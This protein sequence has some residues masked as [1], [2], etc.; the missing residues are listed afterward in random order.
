MQPF[1]YADRSQLEDFDELCIQYGRHVNVLTQDCPAL[2]LLYDRLRETGIEGQEFTRRLALAFEIK[3]GFAHTHYDLTTVAGLENQHIVPRDRRESYRPLANVGSFTVALSRSRAAFAM[4]TR[5]RS[6]WDKAFLYVA[7]T[8]DGDAA[9]RQLQAARSKRR[10]FFSRFGDGFGAVS[11]QMIVE[12]KDDLTTLE[13]QFRT[14]ELHGFGN[15]RTWVF[16][17]PADW[18]V[19]HTSA[20]MR[21]WNSLSHFL[22]GVFSDCQTPRTSFD[23]DVR[24]TDDPKAT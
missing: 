6:L 8:H 23:Q 11:A 5:I 4:I 12:A 18:P 15:I 13:S 3:V 7:M 20:L 1:N 14:P 19:P 21:H 2:R 10:Y 9:V 22:H 16:D 17:T 24:L